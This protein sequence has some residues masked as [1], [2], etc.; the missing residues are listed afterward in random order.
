[1]ITDAVAAVDHP[2]RHRPRFREGRYAAGLEAAVDEVFARIGG[3]AAPRRARG[4]TAVEA[5]RFRRRSL[6][7]RAHFRRLRRRIFKRAAASVTRRHRRRAVSSHRGLLGRGGPPRARR[8]A[9][10]PPM[11]AKTSSTAA[12]RPAA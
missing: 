6:P 11:R 4:G 10:P 9:A 12:S 2:R 8:G 1:V 5:A 3:G 7:A